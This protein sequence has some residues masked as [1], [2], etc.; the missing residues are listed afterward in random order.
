MVDCLACYP[1][2]LLYVRTESE[3]V[4]D[5]LMLNTP[6]LMSLREAVSPDK[7]RTHIH[8]HTHTHTHTHAHTR[9]ITNIES[10]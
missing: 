2:V 10:S 4:F 1:T 6:T 5:A 8:T 3:E 9:T 7:R